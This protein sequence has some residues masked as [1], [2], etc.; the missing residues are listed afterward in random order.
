MKS[1][2]SIFSKVQ[3]DVGSLPGRQRTVPESKNTRKL[4]E[5]VSF[6]EKE[7]NKMRSKLQIFFSCS[8][9]SLDGKFDLQIL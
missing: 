8:S 2:L 3:P 1:H 5:T 7:N 4:K 6:L 9:Y